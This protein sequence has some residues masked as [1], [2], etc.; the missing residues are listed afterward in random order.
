L[1]IE[2]ASR[3]DAWQMGGLTEKMIGRRVDSQK[4]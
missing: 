1:L 4:G 2:L 3:R